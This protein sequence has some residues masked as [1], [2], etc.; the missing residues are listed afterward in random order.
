MFYKVATILYFSYHQQ[1]IWKVQNQQLTD[2]TIL[3]V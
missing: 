1:I 2:P 3:P